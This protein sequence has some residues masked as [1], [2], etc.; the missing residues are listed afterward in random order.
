MGSD[1]GA[2]EIKV[3]APHPGG[4]YVLVVDDDAV[5]R[6][7]VVGA[8]EREGHRVVEATT[9]EEALPRFEHEQLELVVLDIELPG[10]SGL[11]LLLRMRDRRCPPVIL[12]TGREAESDRVLGLDLG[13]E[14]YVVKPFL[15]RELA[16][17][18]RRL[19]RRRIPAGPPAAPAPPAPSVPALDFDT[20]T[21]NVPEREVIVDGAVLALTAK[22][23]DLLAYMAARPR[24][25]L[26]REDI[27]V[28]VWGSS[29]SWQDPATVTEH[30]RRVRRKIEANPDQPRWLLTVR[31]V[32]YRFEPQSDGT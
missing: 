3:D 27:L 15:P 22:E 21:I 2:R 14:D 32:G 5:M 26:S 10:M 19:L 8:L 4:P 7:L 23:F 29:E 24:Q 18:V 25:V 17:R 28:A 16:A 30:I 1:P 20:L 12:L 6:R 31:G 13:A 11:E 9:A